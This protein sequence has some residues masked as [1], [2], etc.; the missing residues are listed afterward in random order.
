MLHQSLILW[1]GGVSWDLRAVW[2]SAMGVAR[3]RRASEY[4]S[5]TQKPS[6]WASGRGFRDVL[7]CYKGFGLD[8]LVWEMRGEKW[9]QRYFVLEGKLLFFFMWT[10]PPLS[11][12]QVYQNIRV[13][14]E[15]L[16][17]TGLV[18]FILCA[19]VCAWKSYLFN[20]ILHIYIYI[21][22]FA[23]CVCKSWDDLFHKQTCNVTFVAVALIFV[24]LQKVATTEERNVCEWC[25]QYFWSH[26]MPESLK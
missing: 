25:C 6:Q 8:W 12:D 15:S 5:C 13:T 21:Y 9:R 23:R 11:F 16:H 20:I 4:P 10:I 24:K 19:C 22:R 7:T 14:E 18:V 1:G 17:Q 3:G 26:W 2:Q